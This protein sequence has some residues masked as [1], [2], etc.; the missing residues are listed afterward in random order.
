M[1]NINIEAYLNRINYNGTLIPNFEVLKNLQ[2][3]L[4]NVP[5][6]NLDI[7][8]ESPIDLSIDTLYSKVVEK[9]EVDFAM[10]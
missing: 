8:Y 6:E 4:L 1:K 7:H 5:F 10:N 2:K 3:K 9:K